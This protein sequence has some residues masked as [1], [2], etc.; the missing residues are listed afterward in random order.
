MK[1]WKWI[2]V[3]GLLAS[4]APGLGSSALAAASLPFKGTL[5]GSTVPPTTPGTERIEVAGKASHL[6]AF[7][8]VIEADL[9]LIEIIGFDP[10]AGLPIAR[11]PFA[12]TF[13]AANG[14]EL[15]ADLVMVGLFHPVN[16]NFPS[17][18]ASGTITG[19]TGRFAG[20]TGSFSVTGGQTSVP[21]ENNDLIDGT[22]HGTIS[23]VGCK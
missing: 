12:S 5:S 15:Y 1:T 3:V 8:A 14:D 11:L 13:E 18:A 16:Q 10:V 19:G 22:F 17:F 21:G 2:T 9:T 20:A 23:A 4:L 6:G 7:A